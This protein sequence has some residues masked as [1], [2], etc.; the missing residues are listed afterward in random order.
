MVELQG[1]SDVVESCREFS[2][3]LCKL[4]LHLVRVVL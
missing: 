2:V 4:T 1:S 3:A